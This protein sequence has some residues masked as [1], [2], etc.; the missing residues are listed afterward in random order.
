[1]QAAQCTRAGAAGTCEPSGFCSLPDPA[2]T[3]GRRYAAAGALDGECVDD[4]APGLIGYWPLDDV[5]GTTTADTSGQGRD[6]TLHASPTWIPGGLYGGAI[7][8]RADSWLEV[9]A[10]DGAG[11][12]H[13][14]TLSLW[15]KGSF[16]S[17]TEND[18]WGLLDNWDSTR[19]HVFARI[20]SGSHVQATAQRS[21]GAYV[22]DDHLVAQSDAWNHLVIAWQTGAGGS[23]LA[24]VNGTPVTMPVSDAAYLPGGQLFRLPWGFVGQLDEIRLYDHVLS[25]AQIA[26]LR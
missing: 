20:G 5:T 8:F 12:P 1:M 17:V 16:A 19:D 13:T 7:D 25:A 15:F 14:G 21:G 22:A 10:L 9:S 2:C 24:N 26:Q 11:F 23:L 4:V 3:S 18:N 6:A